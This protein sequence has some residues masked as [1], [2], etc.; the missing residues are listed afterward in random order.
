MVAHCLRLV[1]KAAYITQGSL[2]IDLSIMCIGDGPAGL[3][4]SVV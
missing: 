1:I 3:R 2:D 4:V